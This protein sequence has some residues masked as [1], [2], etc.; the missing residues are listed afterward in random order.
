ME[1]MHA[2][3]KKNQ[4]KILSSKTWGEPKTIMYSEL[5]LMRTK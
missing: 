2:W 4:N 3:W 1:C 5:E